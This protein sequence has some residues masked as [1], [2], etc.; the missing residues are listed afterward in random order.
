[1]R[2]GFAGAWSNGPE[3]EQVEALAYSLIE[4]AKLRG[5]EPGAYLLRAALAAIENPGNRHPAEE[6]RLTAG[7]PV[8]SVKSRKLCS[9]SGGGSGEGGTSEGL[10][11]SGVRG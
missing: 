4:T 5:E 11:S 7:R 6:P 3:R 9:S 2:N 8:R 1:M 10:D